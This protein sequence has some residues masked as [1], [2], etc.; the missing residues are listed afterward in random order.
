MA[1]SLKSLAEDSCRYAQA[2]NVYKKKKDFHS[3][4]MFFEEKLKDYIK[5]F[6]KGKGTIKVLGIGSGSGEV[7]LAILKKIQDVYPEATII[8]EVL[9]PNIDHIS[10]FKTLVN[11]TNLKNVTFTWHQAQCI[12]YENAIKRGSGQNKFDFIH[13]AQVLYYVEN[14]ASTIELF[15][16]CL[17]SGGKLM[18]MIMSDSSKLAQLWRKYGHQL[19]LTGVYYCYS[20]CDITH[21]LE[22]RNIP[23]QCFELKSDVEITDCFTDGNENGK[24]MVD[25]L[26]HSCNF[27]ETAPS[28]LKAEVMQYLRSPDCITEKDGKIYFTNNISV[29][30][31]DS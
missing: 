29:L 21:I 25:F 10:K 1:T 7:D 5:S 24:L 22:E 3:M 8:N 28:D 11:N 27:D 26:T 9:E 18:I 23:Y 15:R 19:N 14:A 17:Q 4:H 13:M 16:N 30:M 20:C 31:V 6:G 12:K 2:F